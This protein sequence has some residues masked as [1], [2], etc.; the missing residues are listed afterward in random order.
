LKKRIKEFKVS[1]LLGIDL[2]TTGCKA[3]LYDIYGSVLAKSYREYRFIIPDKNCVEEDPEDWWVKTIEVIRDIVTHNK[4]IATN[5]YGIGI[6]CT[7]A[8]VAVDR[9]G[10]PLINAI[11]QL[12]HRS[13]VLTEEM[14]R[15]IPP[16]VIFSKTGNR[17][18]SGTVTAPMILW[19]KR[20][21]PEIYEKTYKFLAPAGFLVHRLTG[22][23]TI[24]FSR[25]STTSL[26]N[27]K[28]SSWDCELL[29]NFQISQDKMPEIFN[30]HEVVGHVT[31]QAAELTSLKE[32][33]PVV[34][35]VMDTVAAGIGIGSHNTSEP[36]LIM[37]S[38]GR[39]CLPLTETGFSD[40]FF[41][42]RNTSEI[43]YLSM[44]PINGVGNS[45]KWFRDTFSSNE[46]EIAKQ[47]GISVFDIFSTKAAD[48]EFGSKGLIYLPYIVGER[49]PHWNSHAKGVFFGITT[50]HQ[51]KEFI[52][53]IME[54]VAYALRNNLDIMKSF[55]KKDIHKLRI[56]GG[57]ASSDVWTQIVADVLNVELIK[58]EHT[59]CE[60]LGA[61]IL[62]GVGTGM[63]SS[64]QAAG[65]NIIKETHTTIPDRDRHRKYEDYYNI[66]NNL[67]NLLSQQFVHIDNIAK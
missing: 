32:G 19:I 26:F 3:A 36:F 38:V 22:R 39:I 62:A 59:E 40:I 16:D 61:A 43:P 57:C 4:N 58:T 13:M 41:N 33:T 37:G 35:G 23:F 44:A 25:A 46:A 64:I 27:I 18:V 56:G 9:N 53:S 11:M 52:R 12:D 1:Y 54:G 10:I 42:S 67:Y 47:R 50:A 8:L 30:S 29:E 14:K 20:N 15:I 34:A 21:L 2:G 5:I 31:K 49:S 28:N 45:M 65:K 7:N 51:K 60:T 17:L 66:F 24:D 63:F 48:S 55:Y 6:S